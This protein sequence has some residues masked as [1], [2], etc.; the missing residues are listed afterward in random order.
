MR[1]EDGFTT[2][3]FIYSC[4]VW[5]LG[6]KTLTAYRGNMSSTRVGER[7]EMGLRVTNSD[8]LSSDNRD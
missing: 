6:G 3:L 7:R 4:V 2:M 5:K 1:F 8:A